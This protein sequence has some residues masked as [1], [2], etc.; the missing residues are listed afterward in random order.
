MCVNPSLP[1]PPFPPLSPLVSIYLFST[2]MSLFLLCEMPLLN[3]F[4]E[5]RNKSKMSLFKCKCVTH[6]HIILS[7]FTRDS[8]CESPLYYSLRELQR[9]SLVTCRLSSV[10]LLTSPDKDRQFVWSLRMTS[11]GFWNYF[12]GHDLNFWGALASFFKYLFY[13]FIWLCRVLVAAGGLL[14]CGIWTLSWGM[15][16]GSSSLTRDWTRAACIGSVESQPL[17]HQGS[18]C[19]GLYLAVLC[20]RNCNHSLTYHTFVESLSAWPCAYC[21]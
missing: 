17:R 1:I 13:L 7:W 20:P 4:Y 14:S 6:Y 5:L 18:P 11:S 21:G 8:C 9:K 12:C 16:V 10:H 3:H 15:P 19:L 2:S